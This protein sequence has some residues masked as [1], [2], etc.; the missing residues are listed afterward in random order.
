VF[1]LPCN[2]NLT[3]DGADAIR[4]VRRRS[5][6]LLRRVCAGAW[7]PGGSAVITTCA[8]EVVDVDGMERST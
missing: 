8:T 4:A 6:G 5:G 2:L 3:L 7:Q 1:Q